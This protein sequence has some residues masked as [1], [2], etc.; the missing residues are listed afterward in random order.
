[1]YRVSQIKNDNV[2]ETETI[3]NVRF[4]FIFFASPVKSMKFFA[5]DFV[6]VSC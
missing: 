5:C 3:R 1:M 4:Y 2:C 6:R